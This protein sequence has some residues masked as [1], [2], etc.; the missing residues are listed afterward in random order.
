MIEG[1]FMSWEAQ[2]ASFLNITTI[3]SKNPFIFALRSF[4]RTK[5][6]T[7]HSPKSEN[8]TTNR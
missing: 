7:Y 1:D 5:T 8:F 6:L 3:L 4:F 2:I